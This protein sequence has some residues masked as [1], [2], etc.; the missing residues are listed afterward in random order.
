MAAG[1]AVY[2]VQFA[3][4]VVQLLRDKDLDNFATHVEEEK[5]ACSLAYR[6]GGFAAGDTAKMERSEDMKKWRKAFGDVM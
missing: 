1:E 2:E 5:A 3:V 4:T 6:A